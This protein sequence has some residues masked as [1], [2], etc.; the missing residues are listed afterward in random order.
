[1]CAL[2]TPDPTRYI[3]KLKKPNF[4]QA[5]YLPLELK[6]VTQRQQ[7]QLISYIHDQWLH[8][9][10]SDVCWGS[11]AHANSGVLNIL[12]E[13]CNWEGI[14]KSH[15]VN[16]F[17]PLQ[18]FLTFLLQMPLSFLQ[19]LL[20]EEAKHVCERM[21]TQEPWGKSKYNTRNTTSA[22]TWALFSPGCGSHTS[23]P[24]FLAWN[25]SHFAIRP[26]SIPLLISEVLA[27]Q[28]W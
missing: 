27:L 24:A 13:Y 4:K 5:R 25:S 11:R 16:F 22:G 3:R 20:N 15:S 21:H 2:R 17:A 10:N 12:Q 18:H 14:S 8:S 6:I 9:V 1:M 7:Q 26:G 19:S 23:E 28:M